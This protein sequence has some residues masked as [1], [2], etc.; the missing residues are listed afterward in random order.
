MSV[1]GEVAE[2]KQGQEREKAGSSLRSEGQFLL[3]I[4]KKIG[5]KSK[6]R[7]RSLRD[8]SQ[9]NNRN[10]DRSGKGNNRSRFPKGMT[11]RRARAR[12]SANT[13]VSPLRCAPVEMT[14]FR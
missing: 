6:R 2:E 1:A 4:V 7:S 12:T 11:E 10:C 8:D 9:S 13:G 5:G 14:Q 3:E